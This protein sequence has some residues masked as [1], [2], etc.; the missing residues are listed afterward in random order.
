MLNL[1]NAVAELSALQGHSNPRKVKACSEHLY[2]RKKPKAPAADPPSALSATLSLSGAL[3]RPQK[4]ATGPR[5][6]LR[7]ALYPPKAT[8]RPLDEAG[9]PHRLPTEAEVADMTHRL[10]YGPVERD[11]ARAKQ[12]RQAE[13]FD[14]QASTSPRSLSQ[15]QVA[16]VVCRMHDTDVQDR[17]ERKQGL[18]TRY[19]ISSPNASP[20]A[21]AAS[22][23]DFT[24]MVDRLYTGPLAKQAESST[25]YRQQY[26]KPLESRLKLS[27]DQWS[28]T[29]TRLYPAASCAANKSKKTKGR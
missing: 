20:K 12:A 11:K 2:T 8:H 7:P 26:C 29:V 15:E 21:A 28:A 25:A 24:A 6:C 1:V 27:S 9:K 13:F 19:G 14:R 23:R 18:D 5:G 22:P 4:K 17:V 3:C 16:E 10:Y